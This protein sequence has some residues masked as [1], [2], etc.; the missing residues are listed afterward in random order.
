MVVGSNLVAVI[1]KYKLRVFQRI[2][3]YLNTRKVKV[4]A[5]AFS[6]TQFYYA[7]MIW[8]FAGKGDV[9]SSKDILQNTVYCT[10]EIIRRS[11]PYE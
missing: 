1:A 11:A 2:R 10:R 7:F 9:K 8:R 3:K 6:D 5:N 4:L